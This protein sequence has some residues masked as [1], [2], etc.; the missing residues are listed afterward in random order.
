MEM[1]SLLIGRFGGTFGVADGTAFSTTVTSVDR[2]LYASYRESVTGTL[3]ARPFTF[4]FLTVESYPGAQANPYGT[5]CDGLT[6]TANG[7]PTVGNPAFGLDV[8]GVTLGVAFVGFGTTVI[9]PGI[10]VTFIGMPG[11]FAYLS[12]DLG[13]FQTG[14]VASGTGTFMLPIP[15][16][17]SIAGAQLATQGLA[18]SV[19]TPS[20]LVSSNGLQLVV[21]F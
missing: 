6:L 16:G 11:C 8:N 15:A 5:G 12:L 21:G 9:N 17:T 1:A 4:D 7:L 18:L 19:A 10:D 3:G 13:L 14:P 2:G 20:L